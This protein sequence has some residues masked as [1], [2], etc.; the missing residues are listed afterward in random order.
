MIFLWMFVVLSSAHHSTRQIYAVSNRSPIASAFK[1]DVYAA[2]AIKTLQTHFENMRRSVLREPACA[3]PFNHT[4]IA[5]TIGVHYPNAE[6]YT[7]RCGVE[8]QDEKLNGTAIWNAVDV[9]DKRLNKSITQIIRSARVNGK[10][11]YSQ[12]IRNPYFHDLVLG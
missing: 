5:Q 12:S 3:F 9:I 10:Q 6:Y 4:W 8:I 11:G 7:T 1:G 2:V